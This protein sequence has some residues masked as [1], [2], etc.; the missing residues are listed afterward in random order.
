VAGGYFDTSG[1]DQ[2][3]EAV[4][5]VAQA[6]R[7]AETVAIEGAAEARAAAFLITNAESAAFHLDRL[8]TQAHNFDPDT[9]DRFLAGALLPATWLVQAQRMR[10][11]FH[12]RMMDLFARADLIIAPATPYPAPLVGQTTM[13]L[14]NEMVAV[15]PNL[16]L[17]TQPI[18]CVGLPVATVPLFSGG[19]PVGVQLIAAPW[20]EDLC[21]RAAHA[22]EAAGIAVARPPRI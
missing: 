21:L 7:A 16:G 4:T 19:M 17:F 8:R 20:R 18:S 3:S 22:L 13:V 14:R 9:R 5:V 2:A 6:L 1:L 12:E 11:W 10:R 15:R